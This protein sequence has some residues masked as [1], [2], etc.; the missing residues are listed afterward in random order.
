MSFRISTLVFNQC[1]VFLRFG[2]KKIIL[3]ISTPSVKNTAEIS[4]GWNVFLSEGWFGLG[5]LP[6]GNERRCHWVTFKMLFASSK[7]LHHELHFH[8][9]NWP[10]L[11]KKNVVHYEKLIYV[12][13]KAIKRFFFLES[14]QKENCKNKFSLKKGLPNTFLQFFKC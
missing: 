9:S 4:K 14:L 7:A 8:Q 3:G 13:C 10:L 2:I 1:G 6:N 12:K 5:E 11:E